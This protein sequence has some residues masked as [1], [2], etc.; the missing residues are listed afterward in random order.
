MYLIFR[1][2]HD[3]VIGKISL[4]K[5]AIGSQAKDGN[6]LLYNIDN[7]TTTPSQQYHLSALINHQ[8]LIITQNGGRKRQTG[9]GG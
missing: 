9:T 8:G 3:D 7:I 4:S 2:S 5:E 6:N 1:F